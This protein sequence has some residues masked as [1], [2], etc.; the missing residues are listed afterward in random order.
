MASPQVDSAIEYFRKGFPAIPM[1]PTDKKPLVKWA[2]FQTR[3]PLKQEIKEM[4]SK[5]PKAMCGL[6]TGKISGICVID[7]DSP[8]ACE[9]IDSMLPEMF[10]TP[11]AVSPRGGRHYYFKYSEGLQTKAAVFP[12]VDIRA[13]G[14]VIIAPPSINLQG[15]QY[16]WLT[17]L[18]LTREVLQ[19]MP[20]SLYRILTETQSQPPGKCARPYGSA[21][22]NN[23]TLYSE[24]TLSIEGVTQTVTHEPLFSLGRRDNDLFTLANSLVKSGMPERDIF[25]YLDFIVRSW[26]ECDET[27]INTKIQSALQRQEKREKSLSEEIEAW[28]SV[29][30]RD[31]CVT[32]CDKELG[33]VTKR[34]RDNRRQVFKR[35]LDRG[36]IERAG[37]KEGFYRRVL[38]DYEP[39]VLDD[40]PVHPLSLKWPFNIHG[41][42]NTLP[43]S[44]AVCAG[45]TD[46]GK[47]A[48]CLNFAFLNRDGF[49]IRY[50]TSEMG[51]EEM[52]NRTKPMDVPVSEWNKIEFIE[53]S[54]NF[55]DLIQPDSITIIDYLEKME[56]FYEVSKDIKRYFDRLKTGFCLVALQKKAGLDFGRGGDFSAEKSRL[57]LSMS[58]GKLKITKAKNW[59]KPDVNPNR[60]ECEFKLVGGIKFIQTSGWRRPD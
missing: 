40:E 17:D 34:D 36:I 18:E 25:R 56:N 42:V 21:P 4:F 53:R 48:F 52:K 10:E 8:E 9:K 15:K 7:C 20:E 29:T 37:N 55:E 51:K 1:S 47:S 59:V 54:C 12:Q 5:Y 44:V 14:G 46:A 3:M 13:E 49:K 38:R 23:N 45:E 31:I 28:I 11:I 19:E 41:L 16:C 58:P 26:G 30:E 50:L 24:N 22:L 35:L 33:I 60:M 39:I 57:Y 43:K 27:W 2:E 6:I 32:D